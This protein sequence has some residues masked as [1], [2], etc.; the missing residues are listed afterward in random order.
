MSLTNNWVGESWKTILPSHTPTLFF[1]PID[2]LRTRQLCLGTADSFYLSHPLWLL[3]FFTPIS[4]NL[5][6]SIS[7]LTRTTLF[8]SRI[9]KSPSIQAIREGN[10]II[11]RMEYDM[12]LRVREM[13]VQRLDDAVE[14]MQRR[15]VNDEEWRIRFFSFALLSRYSDYTLTYSH[16]ARQNGCRMEGFFH[17]Y[18]SCEC[19]WHKNGIYEKW[20]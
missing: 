5:L 19:I 2:C 16:S 1:P 13:V 15:Y 20:E 12:N 6:I 8:F 10:K 11:A 4:P 3:S 7:V 14:Q 17:S 18:I 9:C